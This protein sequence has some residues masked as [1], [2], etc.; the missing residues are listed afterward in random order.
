MRM[1]TSPSAKPERSGDNRPEIPAPSTRP[2]PAKRK[3]A[4]AEPDPAEFEQFWKVYP[5][6]VAKQAARKAFA[7]VREDGVPL[8]TLIAAVKAY[9]AGRLGQ[10]P[11]YTKHPATWLNKGCW[12]DEA[13]AGDGGPPTIDGKT[14]EIIPTPARGNGGLR[15]ARGQTWDDVAREVCDRLGYGPYSPEEA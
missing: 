1:D 7:K 3:A 4:K 6:R 10:D 9:A 12:E 14:G 8:A 5:L 2:K 15:N 11:Q 13:S